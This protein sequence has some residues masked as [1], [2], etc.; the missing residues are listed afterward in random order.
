MCLRASRLSVLEIES[1]PGR[2][3]VGGAILGRRGKS[4]LHRARRWV[5]PRGSDLR[6][7]PQKPDRLGLSEVR[8]KR[9]GKSPPAERVTFGPGKPHPEQGRIGEDEAAR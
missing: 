4:G 7:V 9:W 5:I 3:C 6:K 8:V 1:G 2:R